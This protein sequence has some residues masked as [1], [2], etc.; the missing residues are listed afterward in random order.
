MQKEHSQF[1][2]PEGFKKLARGG[3]KRNP[4][5][6]ERLKKCPGGPPEAL[7]DLEDGDDPN[8]LLR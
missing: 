7:V 3:V 4:G 6:E 1:F 5:K 8:A 2:S